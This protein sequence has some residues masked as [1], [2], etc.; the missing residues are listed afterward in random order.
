MLK[1]KVMRTILSVLWP[2]A[3]VAFNLLPKYWQERLAWRHC[4]IACQYVKTY[5]NKNATFVYLVKVSDPSTGSIEGHFMNVDENGNFFDLY[6]AKANRKEIG[7]TVMMWGHE[8]Y[9]VIS[10]AEKFSDFG[11]K[12]LDQMIEETAE[13]NAWLWKTRR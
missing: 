3:F 6:T 5:Q 10:F 9:V 1:K 8:P 11:F 2:V 13:L 7:E 12:N 4:S